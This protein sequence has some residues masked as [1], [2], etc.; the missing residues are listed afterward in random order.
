MIHKNQGGK[1]R[2]KKV[3]TRIQRWVIGQPTTKG[4]K[5]QVG[6]GKER[7]EREKSKHNR[8]K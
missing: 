3:T 7:S 8:L 6:R 5:N 2:P 1:K 4:Y